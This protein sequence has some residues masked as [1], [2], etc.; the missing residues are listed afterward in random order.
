MFPANRESDCKFQALKGSL[1]KDGTTRNVYEINGNDS[2]VI[3][4][5]TIPCHGNNENEA[6]LYF[7][8]VI[9]KFENVLDCIAEIRCI[10][11]SGKYLIMERLDTKFDASLRASA[12]IPTEVSDNQLKNFGATLHQEKIK[13]L[14]YALL[15]EGCKP[16]KISGEV[17]S[18]NLPSDELINELKKSMNL[19][20]LIS[21]D[22]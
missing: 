21:D 22:S 18:A 16:K 5:D 4:E 12:M 11:Q 15:K 6:T 2:F 7:T 14:D 3:K 1:I 9:N 19:M 20:N 8:A 17:L 13:C 10:S